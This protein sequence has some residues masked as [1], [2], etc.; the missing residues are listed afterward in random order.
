MGLF[1][2]SKRTGPAVVTGD[3][4]TIPAPAPT[5]W[6][7]Q[8]AAPTALAE[9]PAA[10]APPAP[11]PVVEPQPVAPPP[12][13][14]PLFSYGDAPAPAKPDPIAAAP[15]PTA[16]D[17]AAALARLD[18]LERTTARLR[19]D[20][21]QMHAINS[22]LVG[23]LEQVALTNDQLLATVHQLEVR[24]DTPMDAPSVDAPAIA[25]VADL[26]ELRAGQIRLANEQARYEIAFRADLAEVAER[27]R[28]SA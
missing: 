9:P 15:A 10:A 4:A 3:V 18:E 26:D 20:L 28:R 19:A 13:V 27:C 6:M 7:A 8:A 2:R 23:T 1:R 14:A 25:T 16:P 12:A 11:A 24:L 21:D 17:I 22:E 5:T